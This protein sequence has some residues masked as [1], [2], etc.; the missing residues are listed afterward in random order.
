VSDGDDDT[1]LMVATV[2]VLRQIGSDGDV[3]YTQSVDASG[4]RL[5]L[6]E[7]LGMLRFAEDSV[8]RQ[9]MGEAPQEDE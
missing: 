4:D 6:V 5:P 2:T 8:I 3:I 1:V 7:A 9:A